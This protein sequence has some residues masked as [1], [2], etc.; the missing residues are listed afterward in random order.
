MKLQ[1]DQIPEVALERFKGGEGRLLARMYD[2]PGVKIMQGRLEPGSSI[3]L[4]THQTSSETI[5]ILSGTGRMLCGGEEEL[6]PPGACHHCP[7]GCAH[8][9]R[10]DGPEQL[11]FF[12]VV[13]EL[14]A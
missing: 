3:G 8:S 7:R 4:H 1:F 6:L 2:G 14:G 9:L 13:P 5:Y 10:N 12:A 11:C